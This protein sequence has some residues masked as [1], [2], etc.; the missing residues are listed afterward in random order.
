MKSSQRPFR[1][2]ALIP[3]SG[4]AGIY[5]P[6]CK[7]CLELAQAEINEFGGVDGRIVE[8]IYLDGSGPALD[9]GRQVDS[10]A[11]SGGVDALIGMHDSDIRR[12]VLSAA[13]GRISYI[14]T[15]CFEGGQTAPNLLT[16]GETPTQHARPALEWLL[17]E[18]RAKNWYFI[19]NDYSWPR[20]LRS[21]IEAQAA[22]IGI[23]VS[24]TQ[25]VEFDCGDYEDY[26]VAIDE[27]GADGVIV[28]LVGEDSI[29]FNRE[30]GGH[31]FG[32]SL[33]RFC[34][35]IEENTLL[36][37]GEEN[38][39]DLYAAGGYFP[40]ID[41]TENESFK[42]RYS[43]RYGDAAPEINT[44]GV[45]CYEALSLLGKLFEIFPDLAP[46]ELAAISSGL[47]FSS[48]AGRIKIADGHAVRRIYLAQAAGLEF[49]ILHDFGAIAPC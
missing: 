25:F 49:K 18:K 41:I 34:P 3:Q 14:Y 1:V 39:A 23:R 48:P 9:L 16:L 29:H 27:S 28:A 5:G 8:L 32:R 37:I 12:A 21:Y 31:A 45:S 47:S 15:P 26:L 46:Q 22:A 43:A 17:K 6:S 30:F 42:V 2:G 36:A 7:A 11:E 24:A 40:S 4:V 44:L 38:A 13:K 20:H 10:L 33:A 35:L 19:G